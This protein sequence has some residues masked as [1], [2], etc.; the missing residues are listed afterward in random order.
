MR[1]NRIDHTLIGINPSRYDDAITASPVHWFWS[2]IVCLQ[3]YNLTISHPI[4]M[5]LNRIDHT[6]IEINPSRYDDAITAFLAH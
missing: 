6:L 2:K 3:L 5:R 1:L 4:L